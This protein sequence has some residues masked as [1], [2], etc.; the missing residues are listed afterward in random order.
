MNCMYVSLCVKAFI[1]CAYNW[2][3]IIHNNVLRPFDLKTQAQTLT[4]DKKHNDTE[5]YDGLTLPGLVT[6][7]TLPVKG[8]SRR[9]WQQT[10]QRH[11]GYLQAARRHGWSGD[12]VPVCVCVCV[13]RQNKQTLGQGQVRRNEIKHLKRWP[14][15]APQAAVWCCI[16]NGNI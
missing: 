7:V 12:G 1:A 4:A 11:R 14:L 10:V 2:L 5:M 15:K 9:W 3:S 16:N 6:N 8:D 13:C